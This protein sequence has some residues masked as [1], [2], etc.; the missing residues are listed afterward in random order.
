[1]GIIGK[2]DENDLTLFFIFVLGHHGE[3]LVY[4]KLSP[5]C[6]KMYTLLERKMYTKIH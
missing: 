2:I 4:T 5:W 1:M 3:S 6:R